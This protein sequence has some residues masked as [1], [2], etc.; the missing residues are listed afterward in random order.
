MIIP[1]TVIFLS[2]RQYS[3]SQQYLDDSGL[4]LWRTSTS[5]VYRGGS[6]YRPHQ[7]VWRQISRPSDRCQL[8]HKQEEKIWSLITSSGTITWTISIKEFSYRCW[9]GWGCW[10]GVCLW[11]S[12][13]L[14]SSLQ[15]PSWCRWCRS[16]NAPA[17][18]WS[19]P[20]T[21]PTT[22]RW[23]TAAPEPSHLRRNV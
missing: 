4:S 16:T 8:K 23:L 15:S 12:W 19:R 13:S 7:A 2:I 11:A 1:F 21:S 9:R 22:P 10:M 20:H 5:S 17:W 18:T 6:H 3:D 14:I